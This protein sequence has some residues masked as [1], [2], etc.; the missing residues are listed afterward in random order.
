VYAPGELKVV[1]YLKGKEWATDSVKTTG[2][3]AKILLSVDRD[4]IK[5]DGLDLA[6]VK[7]TIADKNGLLVPRSHNLLKFSVTG[8]GEIVAVGNGD[9]ASHEPF[10][11]KQ[12]KAFNGLCLVI[13]KAKAGQA[14]KMVLKAEAEGL[15]NG[16]IVM[17]GWQAH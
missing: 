16:E 10:Q 13:V 3:A 12:R 17:R 11:A 6:F 15:E 2:D 14:G 4:K 9:A 7:V 8:P 5:A 1:A